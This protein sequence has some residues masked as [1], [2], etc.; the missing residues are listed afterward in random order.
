VTLSRIKC[1]TVTGFVASRTCT[2]SNLSLVPITFH[3]RVPDDG[4]LASARSRANSLK[5]TTS[6]VALREFEIR[7]S[8]GVLAAQSR[9]DVSV[10]LCSNT[11]RKYN[12]EL[13]VDVD[14]VQQGL[15][16]LPIT[17][18]HDISL[19]AS[20]TAFTVHATL[21]S[22]CTAFHIVSKSLVE[23]CRPATALL[24]H[25]SFAQMLSNAWTYL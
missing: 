12:T 1:D 19:R 9:L 14:D 2:L 10:E 7:P 24:I 23:H 16:L 18:R 6:T 25:P 20:D 11:V 5:Q 17:A 21:T 13:H 22:I 3:L 15:L 4:Q 8:S